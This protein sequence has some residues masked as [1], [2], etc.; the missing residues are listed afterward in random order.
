VASVEKKREY[1]T[2][3]CCK[4]QKVFQKGRLNT[5]FGVIFGNAPHPSTSF[6]RG[7]NGK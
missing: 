7:Y 1:C 6:S 5:V 4:Y 3:F 2:D